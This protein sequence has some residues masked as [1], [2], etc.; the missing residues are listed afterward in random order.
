M[1]FPRPS[2]PW[3]YVI[4]S[5]ML[6][7]AASCTPG[8]RH[9][10]IPHTRGEARVEVLPQAVADPLPVLLAPVSQAETAASA[11]SQPA[12]PFAADAAVDDSGRAIA[13]LTEAVY[14]EARS[15]PL[16]GQRAVAQVVLNRVRNPAF[17]ASV[18]GVVHQR[19]STGG[20]CQ[21]SYVCDGSM[22]YHRDEAAWARAAG[23]ATEAYRGAV[24]APAGAATF[25][26]TTAV[27][28]WWS[29]RL[30]RIATIG[31]HIFY[32]L[33]DAVGTRLNF[34]QAY[35]EAEPSSPVVESDDRLTA[36]VV[37]F[38]TPAG[39][40]VAVHRGADTIA[41]VIVHRGPQPASERVATVGGVRVHVGSP[42]SDAAAPEGE[43][44]TGPA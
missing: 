13:C 15:E 2:S 20:A 27:A 34:R 16:D 41:G 43:T 5:V 44:A 36:N 11:T 33:G 35:A 14:Y 39:G 12:P 7:T 24:Y 10:A 26:H 19:S 32:R 6:A 1:Q 21:F 22:R 25:Y 29:T 40:S 3:R 17:P 42:P 4:A 38:L 30:A 8:A 28:P 18:C 37:R 23:V 31:A 9:H